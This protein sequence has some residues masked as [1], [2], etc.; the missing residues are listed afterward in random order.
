M[1]V[2]FIEVA[3]NM[4]VFLIF[5]IFGS[6]E[7]GCIICGFARKKVGPYIFEAFLKPSFALWSLNSGS[8]FKDYN[9]I[10]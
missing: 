3:L 2:N 4:V 9:P 1:M 7:G 8:Q 6:L 10:T 5:L